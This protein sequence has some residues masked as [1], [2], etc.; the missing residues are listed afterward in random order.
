MCSKVGASVCF[1]RFPG[2]RVDA[3]LLYCCSPVVWIESAVAVKAYQRSGRFYSSALFSVFLFFTLSDFSITIVDDFRQFS[4]ILYHLHIVLRLFVLV[5][6]EVDSKRAFP[7]F[8]QTAAESLNSTA[9]A[10]NFWVGDPTSTC[11]VIIIIIAIAIHACS[12]LLFASFVCLFICCSF[13]L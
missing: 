5:L 9:T 2:Q 13:P 11:S 3:G 7:P 4:A 12:Y 8:F 10:M 1:L 6:L